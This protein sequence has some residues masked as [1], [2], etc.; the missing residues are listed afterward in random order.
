MKISLHITLFVITCERRE[1]ERERFCFVYV[2]SL[3]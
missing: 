3:S 2:K 1:R